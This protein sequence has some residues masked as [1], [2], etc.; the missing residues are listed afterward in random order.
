M[1]NSEIF[2]G[3]VCHFCTVRKEKVVFLLLIRSA[4]LRMFTN[5]LK[6]TIVQ[7]VVK[8]YFIQ[9]LV[10]LKLQGGRFD[11]KTLYL[12]RNYDKSCKTT[13]K[14]IFYQLARFSRAFWKK[15]MF[16]LSPQNWS[17]KVEPTKTKHTY[18]EVLFLRR[19]FRVV[20]NLRD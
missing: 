18:K 16:I 7:T 10:I 19:V 15:L 17:K 1:R 6:F 8:L 13:I 5:L 11:Q 2:H 4:V 20:H 3:P 14:S 9:K 12:F